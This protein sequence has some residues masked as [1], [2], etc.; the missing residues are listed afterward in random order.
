MFYIAG[1][2]LLTCD[3]VIEVVG[4]HSSGEAEFCLMRVAGEIYVT[5]GSDHTDRQ[6]EI[7][8]ISLSKQ[9]CPKP[10]SATCWKLKDV[11]T[12]WD[13]LRLRSYVGEDGIERLYQDDSVNQILHPDE[14]MP[15]AFAAAPD[16]DEQVVFSGTVP[17]IGPIRATDYFR[18]ELVDPVL[19]RSL[20]CSYTTKYLGG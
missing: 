17:T 16:G 1:R 13:E 12:H 10:I 3:G 9:V 8:S 2:R 20:V 7:S 19:G 15:R 18:A 6:L 4:T 11:I 5:V 14:L